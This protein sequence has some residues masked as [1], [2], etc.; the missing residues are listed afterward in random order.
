MIFSF[1][2][3]SSDVDLLLFSFDSKKR[4]GEKL[5]ELN[6]ALR[7]ALFSIDFSHPTSSADDTISEFIDC[8]RRE[9]QKQLQYNALD[10]RPAA[11]RHQL[12]GLF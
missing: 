6:Q 4:E 10:D 7:G 11:G 1:S 2:S 3:Y 12:D 9:H 5:N 8:A